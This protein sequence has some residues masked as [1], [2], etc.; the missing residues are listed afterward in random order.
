IPN[1]FQSG[2]VISSLSVLW[3]ED[4]NYKSSDEVGGDAGNRGDGICGKG[5]DSGVSGH[6]HHH[7]HP[8]KQGNQ[9]DPPRD[10]YRPPPAPPP[11]Q[12]QE[13]IL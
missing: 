4:S 13:H 8:Y 11:D 9:L 12:T 1:L 3:S 6:H 7:H 2:S 5:D 10:P